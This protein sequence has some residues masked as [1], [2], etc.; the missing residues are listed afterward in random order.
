[1]STWLATSGPRLTALSARA[2]ARAVAQRPVRIGRQHP[3]NRV[4]AHR[5]ARIE[6]QRGLVVGQ[7]AGKVALVRPGRAAIVQ[8]RHMIR[9]QPERGVVV[10]DGAVEIALVRPGPAAMRPAR[11]GAVVDADGGIVIGDGLF[12]PAETGTREAPVEI[13]GGIVAVDANR[14]VV[15]GDRGGSVRAQDGQVGPRVIG[16][17]QQFVAGDPGHVA[18]GHRA[19]YAVDQLRACG[20]AAIGRP[21]DTGDRRAVDVAANPGGARR[22]HCR[23]QHRGEQARPATHFPV[24][25]TAPRRHCLQGDAPGQEARRR[26]AGEFRPAS[27]SPCGD[28]LGRHRCERTLRST[29][30][31]PAAG[32]GTA[33]PARQTTILPP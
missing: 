26:K 32:C 9:I 3:G 6:A 11:G 10:P 25:D 23:K 8:R 2:I 21:S 5:V 20:V 22:G 16:G 18:I 24:S 29:R 31:P 1:M 30:L 12:Q 17:R 28:L 27:P 19:P 14:L 33:W 4:F 15:V 13:G 7:R